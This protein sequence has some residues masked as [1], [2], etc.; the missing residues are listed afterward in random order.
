MDFVRTDNILGNKKVIIGDKYTDLVLETLGKVYI[1]TGNKSQVL[2]Q[3]I[4]TLIQNADT[5]KTIIVNSEQEMNNM[6]YPGDGAFVYNKLNN[7]L[8]MALDNRYVLILQ[9]QT[10]TQ[11]GYVKKS[12]DTMSGPLEI[13]TIEAPLIVHSSKLVNNL[14]AEYLNNYSSNDFA[15]KRRDEI[16]YGSWA[17]DSQCVSN[18]NWIFKE[19][20]RFYRDIVTS[21]S[22]SSPQFAGGFGGY[23][24]RLDANTNTLTIDNIVVRKAMQVYEMVINQISATNGSLWVSNSIK[25]GKVYRPYLI[26]KEELDA[27]N[28]GTREEINAKLNKILWNNSYFLITDQN[29]STNQDTNNLGV[30][31]E[32][33]IGKVTE[34]RGLS[35]AGNINTTP[36]EFIN[37]KYIIWIGDLNKVLDDESFPGVSAFYDENYLFNVNTNS[38]IK[39]YYLSKEIQVTEWNEDNTPK[40]SHYLSTFNKGAEIFIKP[41][42]SEEIVGLKPYYKYFALSKDSINSALSQH[43]NDGIKQIPVP[44]IYII[45]TDSSMN[46]TLKSGD[47]V[48][49]QKFEEN[50]IKYYD[51]IVTSHFKSK[52]YILQKAASVFDTYTEVSYDDTGKV[53]SITETDN[54]TLYNKTNQSYNPETGEYENNYP[55]TEKVADVAVEDDIV[56][57]GNIYNTQRQNAI[58]ITSTDDQGPYIDIMSGLNRPDYSVLYDQPIYKKIKVFIKQKGDIFVQGEAYD[59][60]YQKENPGAINFNQKPSYI[61]GNT[62]K[63]PLVYV[64]VNSDLEVTDIYINDGETNNIPS[65]TSEGYFITNYPTQYSIKYD[66]VAPTKITK[67]RLGNLDGIYNEI[68]KTKQPY[69]YGLYGENVFLTGE[70]YLN[71]GKSVVEFT[72]DSINMAVGSIEVGGSNLV[73]DSKKEET[74]TAYGF[75]WAQVVLEKDKDYVFQAN[76]YCS[77]AALDEGHYLRSYLYLPDWS[78]SVYVDIQSTSSQSKY[79]K[80]TAPQSGT[81]SIASYLYPSGGSRTG[82]VT[83][84][85][86][87]VEQGTIPTDWSPSSDDTEQAISSLE[88]RVT[89]TE[90][91]ITAQATKITTIEGKVT[92]LEQAG[93]V[94][95]ARGNILWATKAENAEI[96]QKAQDALQDAAKAIVDAA[97]ANALANTAN[98][99]AQNAQATANTANDKAT[100]NA[101][102]IQQNADNISILSGRFNADGS[103][104]NTAGLVTGNGDFATL[105]ANAVDA[106][107]NIVKQADISVFVT[108]DEMNNAISNITITADRIKL[109]GYTTINGGF[110]IDE[111]GSMTATS[112]FI[113]GLEI[114]GNGLTNEGFDNDSYIILRNDP[115]N[116][117]VG[118]GCDVSASPGYRI[119]GRFENKRTYGD[120]VYSN[121]AIRAVALNGLKNY[122]ILGT[123]DIVTSGAIAD[124]H[125]WYMRSSG[126]DVVSIVNQDRMQSTTLMFYCSHTNS[127]VT[128]PTLEALQYFFDSNDMGDFLV[129]LTIVASPFGQQ[130]FN[131]YGAG[132]TFP[133]YN[134]PALYD[135]NGNKVERFAMGKGDSANFILYRYGTTYTACIS[136][137]MG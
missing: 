65:D 83:L 108:N 47:I 27:V 9:V 106:D 112:G 96:A 43:V 73:P 52:S 18:N 87:K 107:G 70:F 128:L 72:E 19:N 57:M 132:N 137:R 59:Y 109:E 68:F 94:T 23:G 8:Y 31:D 88:S 32:Q 126:N 66:K 50:N 62:K 37:F 69:G 76:G 3:L 84:N 75:A 82:A 10:G 28:T 100:T 34:S 24:W 33:N 51:A 61:K 99:A 113:A 105:F 79:V 53:E 115:L 129:K 63:F 130:N 86:Y 48:R 64:S 38:D 111:Y 116:T 49:C 80:F 16:I 122:A 85:W 102:L 67:V 121:I 14:N 127:G 134:L 117:F 15:K 22:L 5:P 1:K 133:Q 136:T 101:T 2:D 110:S 93:F 81:Y 103:L 90:E 26:T 20:T 77:Q 42:D 55:T 7:S 4:S 11:S 89:I 118:I 41:R 120:L 92:S 46:P 6:D 40:V 44:T 114:S 58:Y 125:L 131:V 36:K 25:V 30:S 29:L 78:Y 104:K 12:G 74:S 95:E 17:F 13:A 71:N 21:G 123:G 91:S 60:Y 97:A 35:S 45:D 119:T 54:S 56:Q 135:E 39:A 98:N 124:R